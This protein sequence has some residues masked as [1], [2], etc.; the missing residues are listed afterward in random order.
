MS[1]ITFSST[2]EKR[3]PKYDTTGGRA[4]FSISHLQPAG[5]FDGER[6]G[7]QPLL[8]SLGDHVPFDYSDIVTKD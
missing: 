5:L 7:L 1:G 6:A 8:T 2:R 4:G 3:K